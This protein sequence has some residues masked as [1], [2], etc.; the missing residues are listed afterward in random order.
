MRIAKQDDKTV[1]H[2]RSNDI[3]ERNAHHSPNTRSITLNATRML[4]R[5]HACNRR[6]RNRPGGKELRAQNP[7]PP[8][9]APHG[10]SPGP[11]CPS[12]LGQ[13]TGIARHAMPDVHRRMYVDMA[14]CNA[15]AMRSLRTTWFLLRYMDAP[16]SD[17]EGPQR[18]R[19]PHQSL[20]CR[21]RGGSVARAV[22]TA[23]PSS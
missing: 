9:P 19:R 3:D 14:V 23:C 7:L 10:I 12:Y 20:T 1:M 2:R 13:N 21:Y 16:S 8:S 15:Y 5:R 11:F 17:P 18:S 4:T 6:Q 22:V